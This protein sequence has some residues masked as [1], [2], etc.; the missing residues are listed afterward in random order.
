LLVVVKLLLL[1]LPL[2]MAEPATTTTACPWSTLAPAQR[3]KTN[4]SS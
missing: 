1:M 4:E 2:P 3:W